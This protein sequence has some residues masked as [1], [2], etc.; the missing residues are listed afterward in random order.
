MADTNLDGA[1]HAV[2]A[3]TLSE[4]SESPIILSW[5][6]EDGTGKAGTD[7]QEATGTLT[8]APGETVKQVQI[9]VYGRTPEESTEARTFSLR[10][11]PAPDVILS[12]TSKTECR[13]EVKT[14]DGAVFTS[15]VVAR[16]PKGTKGD[17]GLNTY[18]LAKLQG[19]SGTLTEFLDSQKGLPGENVELRAT[20]TMIQWRVAGDE[21]WTDLMPRS[22]LSGREI[23]L[24][25]SATHIQSRY[26]G[27]TSWTN[28][29]A[30]ADLKGDKGDNGAALVPK[31]DW[32]AATYQ[33]GDFVVAAGSTV[34]EAI[35]ILK[36]AAP[37]VSTVTPKNDSTHWV[38]LVPPAGAAGN[39][40]REVQIQ[41][42][43][44]AIQWR[45]AGETGWTDIVSL[46]DLKGADGATLGWLSGSG[47]PAAGIGANG[48][49]YLDISA[50]NNGDVYQKD[51]GSW[52]KVGN[53]LGP[54]G[55]G[56]VSF[57][58]TQE[59]KDATITNKASSPARVREFVE[60]FGFTGGFTNTADDLDTVVKGQFFNYGSSTLHRPGTIGWGRGV[61]LP[62]G[63][64]YVTQLAV[65]N[66]TGKLF[67]RYQT[68][69]TWGAWAAPGADASL[70]I[71][72]PTVL[73]G[74]KVG[75]GLSINATTGVLTATGGG[76]GG[77][78]DILTAV[79]SA[80]QGLNSDALT[81]VLS[82]NV[83]ANTVY[84]VRVLMPFRTT[85][86]TDGIAIG[87]GGTA[88]FQTV[89]LQA[90]AMASDGSMLS[91]FTKTKGEKL[92]F[93]T[94]M[95]SSGDNLL[96]AEGMI[97]GTAAGTFTLQAAQ[98]V[99]GHWCAAQKGTAAALE[100]VGTVS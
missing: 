51:A 99:S 2:F 41:K 17:G 21:A 22:D 19:F 42:G 60:Q 23:E 66:D 33:P 62:S 86:V 54:G 10:I 77:G 37:Y 1:A 24:Q 89:S 61:V 65:E 39:D 80:D 49:M 45:Y 6:T 13:I 57:A 36:D 28:L 30:L 40:G 71:A 46:A 97:L 67:V 29:V 16:G 50:A 20:D 70:P 98:A 34:A 76:G 18:E 15:V 75:N 4:A 92:V 78:S 96:V 32:V 8:F 14:E 48:N 53:I 38:E 26:V 100:P 12:S 91:K 35:W 5:H 27:D 58:S 87:F 72:S 7:Y 31:G 69:G 9:L 44:T 59:A 47:A 90:R 93:P 95:N 82:F 84:S 55:S 25:K 11:D 81:D 56:S 63:N 74:I 94:S 73:G 79:L 68:N 3:V 64:G 52:T 88:G 43:A 85:A 83:V